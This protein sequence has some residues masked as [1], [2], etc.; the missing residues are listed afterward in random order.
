MPGT[1][2]TERITVDIAGRTVDTQ[3]GTVG[4]LGRLRGGNYSVKCTT[5]CSWPQETWIGASLA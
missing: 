4:R 3:R 5:W 2:D 1:V